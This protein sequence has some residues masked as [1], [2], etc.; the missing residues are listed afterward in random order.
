VAFGSTARK[1]G[2]D[3][4]WEVKAVEIRAQRPRKEWVWLPAL[5]LLGLVVALQLRRLRASRD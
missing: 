2:L 5:A 3:P 1:L 4:G